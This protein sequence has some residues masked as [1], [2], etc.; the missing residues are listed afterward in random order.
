MCV[1]SAGA[2]CGW[3]VPGSIAGKLEAHGGPVPPEYK[4]WE[5]SVFQL[6][7][8]EGAPST[9][10]PFAPVKSLVDWV[11]L[12]HLLGCEVRLTLPIQVST[13]RTYP[14]SYLIK[15]LGMSYQNDVEHLL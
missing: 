14:D 9:Q 3:E 13:S 8:L 11:K 5:R 12:T 7:W 10:A 2:V 4:D 6:C 15:R 1:C